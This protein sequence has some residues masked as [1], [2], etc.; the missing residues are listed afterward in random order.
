MVSII[1]LDKTQFVIQ[2]R[3]ELDQLSS[4]HDS[5]EPD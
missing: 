2:F 4:I 1:F 3:Q 5:H